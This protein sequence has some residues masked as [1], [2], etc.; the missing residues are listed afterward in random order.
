MAYIVLCAVALLGVAATNTLIIWLISKPLNALQQSDT[1]TIPFWLAWIGVAVLLN[2]AFHFASD[3][4]SGWLELRL[5]QRVRKSM[6]AQC[7]FVSFPV[8]DNY[9]KGD[10]LKRLSQDLDKLSQFILRTLFLFMSHIMILFFYTVML[11]WIDWPLA[12]FALACS[13][14][15][16]LHQSFFGRRKQIA[17]RNFL[18]AG[19]K[20]M[21]FEAES[22][23]NLR[24][25]S[26][27]HV[28]NTVSKIHGDVFETARRWSMRNKLLDAGFNASL[29]TV[30]YIGA[31]AVVLGGLFQINQGTLSV[32]HLVSFLLYL[33]YLSVPIRG[34]AQLVLQCHE[35]KASAV[36]IAEVL[37]LA[38]HVQEVPNAPALTT[39][40]GR[41]V[42]DQVTFSYPAGP[43]VISNLSAEIAPGE[44]VALVGPSGSGKSTLI[45]LLTRFYDPQ[46]GRIK[47]DETDVKTVSLG[48]LRDHIAVVWQEPFLINDTIRNNLKL[49]RPNAS[50]EDIVAACQAAHAWEFIE[51]LPAKLET[52]L[53]ADGI[54]LSTGQ[55]QRL[56]IAQAFL[57]DAPILILD[58]ASSALDSQA[59]RLIGDAL[60]RLRAGRTTLIIAHRFSA[61]RNVQRVFCFNGDG[62]VTIGTHNELLGSHPA[63]RAAIE[64]QTEP[65][66]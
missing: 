41:I 19:G 47:I 64:W 10:L 5:I 8:L 42:F 60:D 43:Q 20:L 54:D 50:E 27:F 17:S 14:I 63:Y 29:L 38:P 32:G 6:L 7:M 35:D 37:D 45:K 44:T 56:T 40:Q 3:T 4:L 25:I 11:L 21:S 55:K 12:V 48:S 9:P 62:T 33:G 46:Q 2:Q 66:E 57:K 52:V 51:A 58:E 26:S 65:R 34:M 59:E 18:Q 24:G 22:L 13:P 15:F 23:A 28:E 30:I 31:L 36:R 53:G 39:T 49:A 1:S 61:I 16:I